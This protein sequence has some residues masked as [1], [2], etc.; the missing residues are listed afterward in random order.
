MEK[1]EEESATGGKPSRPN[2]QPLACGRWSHLVSRSFQ[3]A[4][5]IFIQHGG[6]SHGEVNVTS[7]TQ[8]TQ[9]QSS[10]QYSYSTTL[11]A[12]R[13][14]SLHLF[15]AITLPSFL[16]G[17]RFEAGPPI[18]GWGLHRGLWEVGEGPEG[19]GL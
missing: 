14:T 8:Q 7:T 1:R 19:L 11:G 15:R 17:I 3:V 13:K 12:E 18:R 16:R 9:I 5:S 10:V 6:K 2:T 4:L